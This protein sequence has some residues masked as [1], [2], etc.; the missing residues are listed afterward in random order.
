[1]KS[2]LAFPLLE[3]ANLASGT[4]N[5]MVMITLPWLVLETTGSA[6]KAGLLAALSAIPGV[7]VS[8]IVGGL[9]DRVGR[10]AVS[11]FSDVMSALSVLLFVIVDQVG[12]LTYP[13]IVAIAVLG[14][15]F[16]PA[17]Y[18]ARKALIT[19]AAV[20]S[21][22]GQDTAN[23][24]HEGIFA[25]GWMLGPALGAGLIARSGAVT[26]LGVTALMFVAAALAVL[27]MRVDDEHGRVETA[28]ESFLE[29]LKEGA[30]VLHADR[31]LFALTM[32]FVGMA[33]LYMPIDTVIWPAYFEDKNDPGSLGA[34]F[35][36]LAGGSVLG[37][38]A[39]G[40]LAQRFDSY[41]L[42][43]LV[44]IT[45]T[46]ALAPMSLLP[47]TWIVVLLG[48]VAGASW[49]P[50][51]PLWNSVVQR[52][53]EPHLQGRVYGLQMSVLYAAPPLGQVAVGYLVDEIGV[54]PTFFVVIGL[55][56]VFA[57]LLVSVPVL[58]KL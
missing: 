22:I 41:R 18:T 58:R 34:V 6:A 19:N 10:R 48:F 50:F 40:R 44:I 43:R 11:I 13:W 49:G 12:H 24:R 3:T 26:A 35:V 20:A 4:A 36:A 8:P 25:V 56:L 15:V 39:F 38:F 21:D 23:G 52:R 28:H 7:I 16:D 5:G 57:V 32:G 2:R 9:I 33:A 42:L 54:Q 46:C 1:M 55:F 53:I 37:A 14:A 47:P 51:N 30:R 17:G 31:P 29:S 45:S 27:A